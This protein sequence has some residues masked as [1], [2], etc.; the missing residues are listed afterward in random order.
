[1]TVPQRFVIALL[2]FVLASFG[3]AATASPR[4]A[5]G[6]PSDGTMLTFANLVVE[7]EDSDAV[8]FAGTSFATVILAELKRLGFSVVGYEDPVFGRDRSSE[9][10]LVLGGTVLDYECRVV[11]S[12]LNCGVTVRW[13]LF[14]RR[15]A[16]V[17]LE[18]TARHYEIPVETT[19][20]PN[21]RA[22]RM[23]K[24]AL[25]AFAGR[26]EFRSAV[27]GAPKAAAAPT[28]RTLSFRRCTAE[29]ALPSETEKALGASVFVESADR[30]GSGV[31]ISPDGLVLTAAHVLGA[32]P[33]QVRLHNGAVYT[34]TVVRR[35]EVHDLA[36]VHVPVSHAPCLRLYR[37]RPTIGA[38]VYALGAPTGRGLEFSVTRGV[39]SGIR[40]DA[41]GWVLQTDASLS[42]G[43]SG[44]PLINARGHIVGI[45]TKK[46]V[47]RGVEGVAFGVMPDTVLQALAL[48]PGES[49]DAALINTAHIAGGPSQAGR[50]VLPESAVRS[51]DPEGDREEYV[52]SHT[53]G[54][55]Y[56]LRYTGAL[57]IGLGLPTV[58]LSYMK[59][60][61]NRSPDG[62]VDSKDYK[63]ERLFNDIGWAMTG[64]GL[65]AFLSSYLLEADPPESA[66]ESSLQVDVGYGAVQVR[67]EF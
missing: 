28:P 7:A 37:D 52:T 22:E 2:T 5:G 36:L 62:V 30:Q 58:G 55:V 41:G 54:W 57:S 21:A 39:I 27:R 44:G 12:D 53:S 32:S 65:A 3:R 26:P 64:I 6:G 34:G 49:T 38:D 51:L 31:M 29:F 25:R 24:G 46:L 20:S 47:G 14:D 18:M 42:P 17:V 13:E 45:A 40:E 67:G 9:A 60:N 23:L 33:P 43:S 56:A 11:D 16:D 59:F 8:F 63:D 19:A 61:K 48:T 10:P 50:L 1:M 15:V 66:E 4:E 35:S